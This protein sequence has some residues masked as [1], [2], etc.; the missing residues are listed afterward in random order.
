MRVSI[1]SLKMLRISGYGV[2]YLLHHVG[3]LEV[4][5]VALDQIGAL[6]L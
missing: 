4:G 5:L 1:C 3:M 2:S 6:S